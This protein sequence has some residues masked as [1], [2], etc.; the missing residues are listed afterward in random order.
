MS[1]FGSLGK[2]VMD[3]VETP[4]A[5]VKDVITMGGALED[6][7]EPYTLTKL[8]DMGKDWDGMKE[9]LEEKSTP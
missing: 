4:V 9:S 7:K 6:K 1:F 2:L 5:I 3:V 8:K